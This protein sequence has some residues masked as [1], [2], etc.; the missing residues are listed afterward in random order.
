VQMMMIA[1]FEMIFFTINEMISLKMAVTDLGGSMVIHM[2]GAFFGLTL[3]LFMRN[4]WPKAFTSGDNSS[5]YHS[6]TF[7]MIGTVFLWMYWPSF[8]A[9][10][11]ATDYAR[12]LAIINTVLSL[13][14]S[15]IAAFIASSYMRHGGTFCMVD[16]QNATLAGGVAMG[17]AA[18]INMHP[19]AAVL[20][21]AIAGVVSVLGYT[22]IQP[23]LATS[24]NLHDTCGVNNLHGMPSLIGAIAAIIALAVKQDEYPQFPIA[25]QFAYIGITLGLAISGAIFT[26]FAIMCLANVN[27]KNYFQD[28]QDWEVPLEERPYFF[29]HVGELSVE[30]TVDYAVKEL[31]FMANRV[32]S[33]EIAA[34]TRKLSKK[35]N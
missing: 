31:S 27:E 4:K 13:T 22:K 26:G 28:K 21:G 9:I 18:D 24:I 11:G 19:G 1:T 32:S 29:D 8:N 7:A 2:F 20:I 35:V 3:S 16:V 34:R 23:M 15:C 33:L 5:V 25:N 6:D 30:D 14:G 10:L 12:H 17:T